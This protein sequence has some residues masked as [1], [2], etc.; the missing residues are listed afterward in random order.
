MQDEIEDV[1]F[2]R[3]LVVTLRA[4]QTFPYPIK[5]DPLD[6]LLVFI[7]LQLISQ[8]LEVHP[9]E[10]SNVVLL[11]RGLERLGCLH[12]EHRRNYL[13]VHPYGLSLHLGE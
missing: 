10:L 9:P 11:V 12:L 2:V 3:P 1:L 7:I 13:A 5:E 4:Y 6:P 8:R